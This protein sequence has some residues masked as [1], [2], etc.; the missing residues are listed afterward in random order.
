MPHIKPMVVCIWSGESKPND[1]NE[2]LQQFVTELNE[3]LCQG[4][5]IQGHVVSA[6]IRCFICDAPARSFIKGG[7]NYFFVSSI[8]FYSTIYY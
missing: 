6:T 3:I 1:L 5:Q 4:M 8:E 7:F 2:F